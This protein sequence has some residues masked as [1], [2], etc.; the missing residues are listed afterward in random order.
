LANSLIMESVEGDC[1]MLA[2]PFLGLGPGQTVILTGIRTDF[3]GV[4]ESE[5]LTL[6]SVDIEG[7]FAVLLLNKPLEHSYLR[8][9]VTINA[10]AIRATHGE[11]TSEIL[12][13]SDSLR[14]W[15]Q[16][17]L[18]QKPLTFTHAAERGVAESSLRLRIND[19][20]WH[21]VPSLLGAGSM[22]HVFTARTD[23]GGR[24]I[25][26]FGDG[27]TGARLPVGV[28]NVRAEY[29]KGIGCEGL[30]QANTL[31]QLMT[32]PLGVKGVSNPLQATD[33][34]DPESLEDVRV[35]A[36]LSLLTFDRVVSF[37]DY[38]D[39][40]RGYPGIAKAKADVF[41]DGHTRA[42][43][44]TVAGLY[45][46]PVSEAALSE[47][48]ET[49]SKAGNPF[50]SVRVRDHRKALF[51]IIGHTSVNPDYEPTKVLE[52]VRERLRNNFSFN[53]RE[54]G[55]PVALSEVIGVIQGVRGVVSVRITNFFRAATD[56]PAAEP[57]VAELLLAGTQTAERAAELLTLD[58]SS[59]G[60]LDVEL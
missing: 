24:T 10:N 41:G 57:R 46:R 27:K 17:I 9:T 2:K 7:G 51:R 30:V 4:K 18:A 13:G 60:G 50:L 39:F 28:E 25:V 44:V 12:G 21:E 31:T 45:D 58:E 33:A 26:E 8:G 15:E 56:T 43:L 48:T 22:D 40:A 23:T 20:L 5:V 11:T 54:L 6:K 49:F 14:S 36:P 47:L 1:V 19:V 35:N 59:L 32:R 52:E 53:M 42:V 55:Q 3:E 38:E 37:Q 34:E 29:R 16:F